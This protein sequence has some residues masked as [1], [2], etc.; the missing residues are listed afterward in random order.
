MQRI[1]EEEE[2]RRGKSNVYDEEFEERADQLALEEIEREFTAETK[3]QRL[4]KH[5]EVEYE[6]N[7]VTVIVSVHLSSR[8]LI[9]YFFILTLT[10][11]A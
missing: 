3:M 11:Y 6:T 5:L 9:V 2:E 8:L 4:A 10:L 7:Y 1:R